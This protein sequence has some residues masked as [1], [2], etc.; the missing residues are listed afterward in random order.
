MQN[1]IECS[2]NVLPGTPC[3]FSGNRG[4]GKTPTTPRQ[5][6]IPPR[7]NDMLSQKGTTI[8]VDKDT[9]KLIAYR[10][11]DTVRA[12]AIIV[13]IDDEKAQLL[14]IRQEEAPPTSIKSNNMEADIQ[15][16]TFEE[17][18]AFLKQP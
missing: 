9:S 16:I 7:E 4:V 18:N 1:G 5:L 6:F 13:F 14:P 3:A 15:V 17:L 2:K 12:P 10:L 11:E 8:L